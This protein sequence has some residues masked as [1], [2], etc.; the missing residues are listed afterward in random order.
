MFHRVFE[1]IKRNISNFR[2]KDNALRTAKS[3]KL[4]PKISCCLS[5]IFSDVFNHFN[6]RYEISYWVKK[7]SNIKNRRK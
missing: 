1:V 5:N 7:R 6:C 4:Y 2:P 3:K